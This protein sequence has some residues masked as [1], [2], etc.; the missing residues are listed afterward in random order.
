MRLTFAANFDMPVCL[1]FMALVFYATVENISLVGIMVGENRAVPGETHD[2]LQDA[3]DLP[4]YGRKGST[5]IDRIGDTHVNYA[6][7]EFL[8]KLFLTFRSSP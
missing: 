6:S 8:I 1:L 3:E 7:E 4:T 5:L 2:R